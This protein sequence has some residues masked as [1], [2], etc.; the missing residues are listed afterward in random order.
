MEEIKKPCFK[1]VCPETEE[2]LDKDT[3]VVYFAN[4]DSTCDCSDGTINTI[5]QLYAEVHLDEDNAV[6]IGDNIYEKDDNETYV[7]TDYY[8]LDAPNQIIGMTD[9]TANEI[10]EYALARMK[11]YQ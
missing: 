1:G 2:W 10:K 4:R 8:G 3:F 7:D 11:T 9:E 6:I 5:N